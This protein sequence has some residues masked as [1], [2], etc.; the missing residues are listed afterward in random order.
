MTPDIEAIFL[1][2]GN[3]LRLLVKDEQHIARARRKLVELVGTDEEPQAF[4]EKLNGR[5]KVYREWA[6]GNLT[7]APESELWTRWLA[8]D[9]PPERIAPLAVE[10][11]YEFRQSMG[12]RVVVEHG[13]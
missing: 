12:R 11:T 13:R 8:P 1:D 3:T 2:L 9:F 7:E 5:Y 6:F 4:W 10:L